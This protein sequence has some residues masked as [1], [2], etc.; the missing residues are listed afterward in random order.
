MSANEFGVIDLGRM[1]GGLA[2]LGLDKDLR[3][4]GLSS[5]TFLTSRAHEGSRRP[6]NCIV[7]HVAC[8]CGGHQTAARRSNASQ[9]STLDNIAPHPPVN[10]SRLVGQKMV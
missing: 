4:V 3:V 5:V 2:H 9:S 6:F 7:F 10:L 1:G 8:A